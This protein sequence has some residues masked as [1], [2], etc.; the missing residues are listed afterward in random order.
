MNIMITGGG[1]GGHTSPAV[2][3]VEEFRK[4]DPQ[5]NL[6][7]IGCADS[8]EERVS[9][10]ESIPFRAVPVKGW[11]RGNV[12]KKVVSGI[13]LTRG[14]IRSL[15]LLRA[16]KPQLVI[17]V[18]GY[19]SFPV[20][21]AAQWLHVPTVIHEQ[22]K[23]MG[24]ANRVLAEHA[25]KVFLSFEETLGLNRT[26]SV[27]WVGNPVRA[28][29]YSPPSREEACAALGLDSEVPI[30]L[31]YGGSQGAQS[32]NKAVSEL[33]QQEEPLQVQFVW[34]TGKSFV[35]EAR[36]LVENSTMNVQVHAFI[37][38]MVQAC[39]AATLIICR[40]GAS[41]TAEIATIGR[42][43]ILIPYP[44]ATDNHQEENARAFE[45]AGAAKLM[46]DDQCTAEVLHEH[47]LELLQ[48]SNRL[49]NMEEA[50]KSIAHP[51]AAE[52]IVDTLFE[53]LFGNQTRP[54]HDKD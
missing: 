24:M 3:I 42:A 35:G 2:A 48:D 26:E 17:G 31:V 15:F 47:I 41:S 34:M 38:D 30:V 27:E 19:V 18:G 39:A 44:Y 25:E 51:M 43:S 32:I 54:N 53:F 10:H 6:Q 1:T 52:R 14:L 12:V 50:A 22:N 46:L 16:F 33:L 45:K 4:R 7:W 21:K 5:L 11:P 28:G 29:F 49:R 36:K 13:H 23:Q 37:D 20:M 40:S 9:Q 8:V